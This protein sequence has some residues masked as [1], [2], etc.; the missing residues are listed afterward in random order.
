MTTRNNTSRKKPDT[1]GSPDGVL[2]VVSTPIGNLEDITLRALR[3]LKESDYVAAE[4]TRRT[5][6]LLKHFGISK[7]LL[8]CYRFNEAKRST[9]LI[10]LLGQGKSIALVSDAGTPA[11]SDPGARVVQCTLNAGYRVECIPGP[12]ALI[13]ALTTAGLP[14]DE[15][16][17]IGFLPNRSAPRKRKLVSLLDIPGTLVCYESRYRI[18][19]LLDELIEIMPN[20]RVAIGREITKMHEQ[21]IRGSAMEVK[22]QLSSGSSKGEF[23]VVVA[24]PSKQKNATDLNQD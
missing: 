22:E 10:D 19:K 1:S 4:D 8:S 18:E 5:G 21:F 15:F 12:C 14:T 7:P 24:P 23:V 13:A 6:M 2:Y 20:H 11:I 9:H 17:F 16:H 3:I